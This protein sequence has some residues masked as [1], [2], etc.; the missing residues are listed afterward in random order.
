MKPLQRSTSLQHKAVFIDKDGTL[1]EDVPFN[2]DPSL[3]TISK[4]TFE[5]LRLLQ[6]KG[7]KILI[8]SNQSGIAKGYFTEP[9]LRKAIQKI[10]DLLEANDVAIDAFYYCPHN[11]FDRC[12]CRKPKPG[13]FFKAAADHNIDL[14]QSWMVGDI[15]D[16]VEA[17][18]RA[19]CRSLLVYNNHETEWTW[20]RSRMP[21]AIVNS[22]NEAANLILEN[23]YEFVG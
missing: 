18:N 21:F 13:M 17:G 22:I 11:T 19:G 10:S 15:L 4:H 9:D 2:V 12:D 3:I 6:S 1:I 14:A 7:Y 5:G 23:Q 20:S 16:D 8:V